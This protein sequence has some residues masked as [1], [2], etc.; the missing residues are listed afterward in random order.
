[1]TWP[2]AAGLGSLGRTGAP[3]D[4][5]GYAGRNADGHFSLWNVSWV[6]R[7]IVASPGDL[8]DANIFH[9]HKRTLA[10]SEAN[11]V[12]G[13]VGAPVWW[14]T[15]N[16]YA[17]LNVVVLFGFA[18]AF[19]GAWLLVRRLT[20]DSSAATIAAVFYAFCPYVF[21][22]TSHIQLM[23]TGG[24][25]LS[26]LMLHRLADD[27]SARRGAPLGLA[28]M[29]QALACAYYGIFA[30]LMVGFGILFF[31]ISRHLAASAA[32]WKGL[33][34]AAGVSIAG[35]VPF[36]LPFID[37]QQ[38][39]FSRTLAEAA[40]YS[41]N[42]SSYLTSSAP[43]HRWLRV[44]I[45]DWPA[46]GEVMFPGMGLL[47]FGAG[48]AALIA[49]RSSGARPEREIALL[50]G[51]LGI[52]AFWGS[53]G[54]RAGLYRVLFEIPVFSFLRVPSRLGIVVVLCL[55]VLSAFALKRLLKSVGSTRRIVG[56]G[57]TLAALAELAIVPFPWERALVVPSPYATLA[58]LPKAPVALFPFHGSRGAWHLNSQYM[59][60]S[61][62]HW[63]PMLNGYSDYI[64]PQTR[65]DS[66]ALR[67]FPSPD[68][69]RILKRAGV[70]YIGVHWDLFGSR[71]PEIR[72]R[73]EAYAS[74]LK[75][76]ASDDRMT[77]Y[78][79]VTFP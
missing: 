18:T 49:R 67:R 25:P 71:A 19:L 74:N 21:S 27:P 62:T 14:V 5:D 34:V 23:L 33:G 61:T 72:S 15:G 66:L 11:I 7:T 22:H 60:F 63:M 64:P 17:T 75:P 45:A 40:Q 51:L 52:L 3:A 47:V 44:A 39:G 41:A 16:P 37:L 58:G 20:G 70:R 46:Y 56:P 1:M 77:L 9:P 76:L 30:A 65:T 42:A 79:I 2:L 28:L 32:W 55:S 6:A 29:I 38:A 4:G 53:F 43:A 36:F 59:V 69:F 8:F 78:E 31:S 48:G 50:Y 35:V 54:P 12:A 68:S 10:Y 24:I 26:M 57:L 73:L 13:L